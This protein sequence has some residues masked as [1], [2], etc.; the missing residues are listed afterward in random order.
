MQVIKKKQVALAKN[1]MNKK[2]QVKLIVIYIWVC[3]WLPS[4]KELNNII[5]FIKN[6]VSYYKNCEVLI[7]LLWRSNF[8]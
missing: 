2:F 6:N 5:C 4:D 3:K 8:D 7:E 1:K